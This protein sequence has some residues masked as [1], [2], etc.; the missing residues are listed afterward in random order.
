MHFK[1][2]VTDADKS[3]PVSMENMNQFL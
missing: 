3:R 1:F 2:T